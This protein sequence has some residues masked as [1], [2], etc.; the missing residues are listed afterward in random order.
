MFAEDGEKEI[1]LVRSLTKLGPEL[2]TSRANQD[3]VIRAHTCITCIHFHHR[4]CVK[5]KV[6]QTSLTQLYFLSFHVVERRLDNL[7]VK[8]SK[9]LPGDEKVFPRLVG[10]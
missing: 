4:F 10:I 9:V 1:T 8:L 2:V 5:L 7:T 6:G 3:S